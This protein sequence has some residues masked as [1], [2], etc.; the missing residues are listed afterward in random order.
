MNSP[1]YILNKLEEWIESDP[2]YPFCKEL[3][4]QKLEQFKNDSEN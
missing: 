3:L 4:R 2:Y 1:E